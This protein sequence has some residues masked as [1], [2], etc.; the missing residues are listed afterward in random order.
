MI[1]NL[2]SLLRCTGSGD[3]PADLLTSIHDKTF[4]LIIL[5]TAAAIAILSRILMMKPRDLEMDKLTVL[6][7]AVGRRLRRGPLRRQ[8]VLFQARGRRP[9][10]VLLL[11]LLLVGRRGRRNPRG[12]DRM[13]R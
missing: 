2:L 3:L 4:I 9:A 5:Q 13:G 8:P 12:L 6:L 1:D 7:V 11:V 10:R